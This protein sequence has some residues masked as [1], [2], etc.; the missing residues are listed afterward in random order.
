MRRR[1]VSLRYEEPPALRLRRKGRDMFSVARRKTKNDRNDHREVS[2]HQKGGQGVGLALGSE[3]GRLC[4]GA[5]R[6]RRLL[7]MLV[8][9]GELHM[10]YLPATG[11]GGVQY[12]ST[13]GAKDPLLLRTEC[14]APPLVT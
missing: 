5:N 3:S 12:Y 14:G 11:R 6:T 9:V 7:Y 8:W 4:W 13:W 10:L 1:P 2:D